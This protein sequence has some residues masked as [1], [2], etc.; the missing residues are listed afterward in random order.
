VL[1]QQRH[2]RNERLILVAGI[3]DQRLRA[4]ATPAN[5]VIFDID[6]RGASDVGKRHIVG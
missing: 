3:G 6:R 2:L 5:P 1:K 4:Q